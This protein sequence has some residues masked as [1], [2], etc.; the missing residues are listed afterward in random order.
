MKAIDLRIG[1]KIE[2]VGETHEVFHIS[3]LSIGTNKHAMDGIENYTPILLSDEWLVNLGFKKSEND[4][5]FKHQKNFIS[6]TQERDNFNIYVQETSIA[7]IKYVHQL[8]N[9]HFALTGIEL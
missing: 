2:R 6:V 7:V 5:I 3:Q 8:Q 1:N 9:I 4:N